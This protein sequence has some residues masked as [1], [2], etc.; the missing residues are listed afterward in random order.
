MNNI[1]RKICAF[2]MIGLCYSQI[3]SAQQIGATSDTKKVTIDN[4][5][6]AS[7]DLYMQKYVKS[8]GTNCFYHLSRPTPLD[9]QKVIRMNRDTLY[10]VVALD[11][12]HPVTIE[13]PDAG[14][15]YISLHIMDRDHFT[16]IVWYKPGIY[17]I[18]QKV[19]GSRYGMAVVRIAVDAKDEED[20][21]TVNNLQ[22]QIKISGGSSKSIDVPNWD[23]ASMQKLHN[24]ILVLGEGVTNSHKMFGTKEQVDPL[25]HMIG[26]A[27]GFGG[28]PEQY[29]YYEIEYPDD[30][31]GQGEFSLTVNNVPVEAFWSIT[32]YNKDGF[33]DKNDLNTYVINGNNAAKNADGTVTVHFG[34]CNSDKPNCLPIMPGWN[35]AVRM[36]QPKAEILSGEWKFPAI[37]PIN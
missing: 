26:T 15:R 25:L 29:T 22:K 4:F 28:L 6:R 8:I 11:V 3:S 17:T 1:I 16:P 32:V 14:E 35:Y 2:V 37:K 10:S 19:L 23:L 31:N 36:Y 34:A 13:V 5:T 30:G 24:A 9:E 7:N 12:S 33:I 20:I 21:K 18:D 27:V